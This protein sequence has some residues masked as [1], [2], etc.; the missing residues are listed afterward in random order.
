MLEDFLSGRPYWARRDRDHLERV[1]GLRARADRRTR[2]GMRDEIRELRE[3]LARVALLARALADA[4]VKGGVLT[5]NQIAEMMTAADLADGVA[6]G[7]L[8]P[9]TLRPRRES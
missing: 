2:I 7:K 1:I 9:R 5:H 4:C 8:D 6:D 3:D